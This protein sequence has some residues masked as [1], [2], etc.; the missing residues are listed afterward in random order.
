MTKDKVRYSPAEVKAIR[1]KFLLSQINLAGLLGVAQQRVDEWESGRKPMGI[2]YS[3]IMAQVE[4]ILEGLLGQAKGSVP[5]FRKSMHEV[6]GILI[7]DAYIKRMTN[8][9]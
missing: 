3:R 1:R 5:K 2:A 6:Y 8:G 9:S 4:G 7:T